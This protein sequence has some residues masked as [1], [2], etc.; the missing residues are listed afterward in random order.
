M[1]FVRV[2][3]RVGV[4]APVCRAAPLAMRSFSQSP[5]VRDQHA[6]ETFEEFTARYALLGVCV[7]G[8]GEPTR[9]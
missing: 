1:S 8:R 9:R 2:A 6:E 3:S 5:A 7:W 4:R